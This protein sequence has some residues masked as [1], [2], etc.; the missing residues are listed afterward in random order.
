MRNHALIRHRHGATVNACQLLQPVEQL[1]RH[2]QIAH[3]QGRGNGAGKG[4]EIDHAVAVGM[5]KERLLIFLGHGKF[6]FKIVLHDPPVTLCRPLEIGGALTGGGSD[7]RRKAAIGRNV[8]HIRR[9]LLQC[10]GADAVVAERQTFKRYAFGKIDPGDSL[11]ARIFERERPVASEQ[12]H[13]KVIE[14]LRPGADDHLLRRG[15]QSAR[16]DEVIADCAAQCRVALR[17]RRLQQLFTLA[18]ERESDGFCIDGKREAHLAARGAV[19]RRFGCRFGQ[20]GRKKPVTGTKADKYAAALF[21]GRVAFVAQ[22]GKRVLHRDKADTEL[23]AKQPFRR[24][25]A[26]GG[27]NFV[28]NV[29]AQLAVKLQIRRRTVGAVNDIFHL[30][31]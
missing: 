8:Q 29:G 28:R 19:R 30:V 18:H 5:G 14:I 26:P 11:V 13:Q 31:L 17:R 9:R 4:V 23:F 12:Q 21:G 24:Q 7:A 3:P 25:T 10:A 27:I 15:F 6:R 1:R 20:F 2:H 22:K 16:T